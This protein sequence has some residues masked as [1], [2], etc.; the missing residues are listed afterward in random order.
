MSRVILARYL[1]EARWTR[2]R[3]LQIISARVSAR[4]RKLLLSY[5]FRRWNI[6]AVTTEIF[7]NAAYL[8]VRHDVLH[9]LL[10]ECTH[11]E[12]R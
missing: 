12:F 6:P 5:R 11:S 3:L 2:F 9:S 1:I 8:H 7:A 4:L 10:T